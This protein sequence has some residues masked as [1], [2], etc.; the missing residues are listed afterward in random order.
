VHNIHLKPN[1][2]IPGPRLRE[3]AAEI[4]GAAPLKIGY[5]GRAD[6]PKGAWDWL[7]ALKKLVGSGVELEAT[8]L[9]DGPILEELRAKAQQLG[10][11]GRVHFPGFVADRAQVLEFLRNSHLLLFCHKVPESPRVLMEALVCGTP[12][13]G[14]D[15]PYPRDLIAHERWGILT[16]QHD[17]AALA[18]LIL[19]L[20]R[21][22]AALAEMVMETSSAAAVFND[23]A[24][25]R[26]R[27][28]LI[29]R[30]L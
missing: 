14:Y 23:Q 17:V 9:G 10:L 7:E 19:M 6:S 28:E 5:V 11:D 26:H 3:K 12:I 20:D 24:V 21:D 27:S 25:F 2:A 22:R 8:W 18:E 30:Y 13:F 29:K 16:P 15:S 1:D 4:K